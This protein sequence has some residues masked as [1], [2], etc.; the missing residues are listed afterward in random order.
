MFDS[1]PQAHAI[2]LQQEH[3]ELEILSARLKNWDPEMDTSR[4]QIVAMQPVTW[5]N[6]SLGCAMPGKYYTQAL[7]PGFLIWLKYFDDI[8]EV[9]TDLSLRSIAVPGVGFI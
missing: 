6:G 1:V 2:T 3:K 8:L 9:H 5:N 4:L 7:V